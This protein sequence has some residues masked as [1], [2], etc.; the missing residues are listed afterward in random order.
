MLPEKRAW[1]HQCW[2]GDVVNA[3]YYLPEGESIDNIGY[4][5]PPDGGGIDRQRRDGGAEERDRS[6]VLAHTFL[7][8]LLDK[9]ALAARTTAGSATNR[10][11]TS[12]DPDSAVA[13]GVRPAPPGQRRSCVRRTSRPGQQLLQ[14]SLARRAHLGR[15]LVEVHRRWLTPTDASRMPRRLWPALAAP[16]V[17]WLVLLFLV[18]FY[19]VLAV[20][21]GERRPDLRQRGAGVEPARVGLRLV[22]RHPRA[23][24]VGGEL[25]EVFIRTVRLRRRGAV[26][27]LPDRLSGRLLRVPLRRASP[28]PAAR[29][30]AGAVLD[31]LPDADAGVGQP[32]AGGRLRQRH[33]GGVRTRPRS[34]GSTGVRSP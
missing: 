14:L 17:S 20:A 30:A 11:R 31:Q 3:Q 27:L 22:R 32:A 15:R 4:W 24:R 5:Y 34:T 26:D 23:G 29:P 6:P 12:L 13:D 16:G 28:W 2:S 9:T 19:G 21:F 33:H 7:N 18:P 10:R 8:Y 25:G 1:V